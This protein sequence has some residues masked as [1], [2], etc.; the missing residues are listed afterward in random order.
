[1][2][3]EVLGNRYKLLRELGAGGMAS[4]YLALDLLEDI[5]VA[6][7][8]LYP[9]FTQDMSYVQRFIREAKLA[10]QIS[11]EHIVRILN[12]G[13]DRDVHYLVMEHIQGKDLDAILRE[14]GPLPW[15]EAL[16]IAAQV[17]LA[18]DVAN[19]HGVVHRDIKPQN[20]MLTHT[21]TIKVLDFGI[22]R[23]HTLPSL[24]TTGFV[25]S[26]SYIAPE[27]AMGDQVD[28]RTDIYSLGVA[29]YET[30]CGELPFEASS[31][32]S[33]ISKHINQEPPTLGLH[34]SSLPP[35]V[36]AL[37]NKMLSKDPD[38]RH[39]TSGEL[40]AA[41]ESALRGKVEPRP[42]L[43]D[44]VEHTQAPPLPDK[45]HQLLLSSL[46]KRA[47]EAQEALEWPQAMNLFKNIIKIAPQYKDAQER[48]SHASRQARLSTLYDGSQV[49]LETEHWQEAID[50][51]SEIVSINANYCNAA[52]ML[53]QAGRS[54]AKVKAQERMAQLYQRGLA[55]YHN[56]E[57]Q[58]A[59]ICFAQVYKVDPN[60]QDIARISSDARRRARWSS[61]ILGR[62]GH[63]LTR[64]LNAP[65]EAIQENGDSQTPS[66]EA[67]EIGESYERDVSIQT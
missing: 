59:D 45:A 28:I 41:I 36:E 24:T 44:R 3:G 47:I 63:K 37:V 57:W 15:R 33:I 48:L 60:Y 53:M 18:L 39:Q 29:L 16:Q 56:R 14:R 43:I 19:A 22:A 23:A 67:A 27:Q 62:M 38:D 1:V 5:Q 31:P 52:D 7:K 25:G 30:L 34:E 2:I 54:L 11:S 9:H 13:S 49:A 40:L 66:V 55:H 12:Y 42:A 6:V 61:S 35:A 17:A 26:P 4:V 50:K 46:Y 21:G 51:L 64:L 8:I 10:L 65:E 20:I 32:W 58:E